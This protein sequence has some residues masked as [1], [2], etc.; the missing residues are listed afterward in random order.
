MCVLFMFF[1]VNDK[2]SHGIGTGVYLYFNIIRFD[3]TIW[4]KIITFMTLLRCI[5]KT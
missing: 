3:D 2:L 1:T 4:I 5:Q